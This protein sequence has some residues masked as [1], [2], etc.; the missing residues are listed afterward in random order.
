MKVG[1]VQV[2]AKSDRK[3]SDV[4]VIMEIFLTKIETNCIC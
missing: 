4:S 1:I 2:N 3:M